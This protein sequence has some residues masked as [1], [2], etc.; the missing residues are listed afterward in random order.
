[1]V[2]WRRNRSYRWI[3]VLL[4]RT[5][6]KKVLKKEIANF[7]GLKIVWSYG[8]FILHNPQCL[9]VPSMD[10]REISVDSYTF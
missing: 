5:R 9:G 2:I 7:Q 6:F 10:S 1:M 3:V 4:G 8:I